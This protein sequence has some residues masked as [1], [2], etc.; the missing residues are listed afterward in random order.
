MQTKPRFDIQ[1]FKAALFTHQKFKIDR[2]EA[3]EGSEIQEGRKFCLHWSLGNLKNLIYK[4]MERV[5]NH[6]WININDFTLKAHD[7]CD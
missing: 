4:G 7:S 6:Q 2:V 3:L 5:L 1:R